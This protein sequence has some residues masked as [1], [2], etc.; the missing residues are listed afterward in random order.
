ML[1][2]HKMALD[3][4]EYDKMEHLAQEQLVEAMLKNDKVDLE[5]LAE[6]VARKLKG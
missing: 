3:A 5:T 6:I 1:L 4:F 2:D